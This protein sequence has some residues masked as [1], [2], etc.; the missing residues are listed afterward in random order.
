MDGCE[1]RARRS[2]EY[3]AMV[4]FRT[5]ATGTA[6]RKEYFE[7]GHIGASSVCDAC[8]HMQ[9]ALHMAEGVAHPFAQTSGRVRSRL[10]SS[11]TVTQIFRRANSACVILSNEKF[12]IEAKTFHCGQTSAIWSSVI[13]V[14]LSRGDQGT[15]IG[16]IKATGLEGLVKQ[17]F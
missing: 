17:R 12:S 2:T 8:W 4:T 13:T 6:R 1:L 5:N 15:G 11:T 14:R 10:G 3:R 9:S 7:P 16:W